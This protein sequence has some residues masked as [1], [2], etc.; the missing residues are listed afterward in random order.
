MPKRVKS[1]DV[2]DPNALTKRLIRGEVVGHFKPTGPNKWDDFEYL[3]EESGES[4]EIGPKNK[5]QVEPLGAKPE[6]KL[7]YRKGRKVL[8]LRW[9]LEETDKEA[10]ATGNWGIQESEHATFLEK[11]FRSGPKDDPRD[12]MLEYFFDVIVEPYEE[13]PGIGFEAMLVKKL[14]GK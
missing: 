13:D 12:D 6:I 10:L 1:S 11:V 7:R 2:L 9:A 5:I 8:M 14:R 3:R 4:I